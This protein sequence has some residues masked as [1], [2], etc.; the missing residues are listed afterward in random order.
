MVLNEGK[1]IKKLSLL[2]V[3]KAEKRDFC[4]RSEKTM[5]YMSSRPT[6]RQLFRS[7][8]FPALLLISQTYLHKWKD[9]F[10]FFPATYPTSVML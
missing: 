1:H 6:I 2:N 8:R 9:Y 3:M 7:L 5:C 4:S 10:H